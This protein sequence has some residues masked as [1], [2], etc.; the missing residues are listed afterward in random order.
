M[1]DMPP[2]RCYQGTLSYTLSKADYSMGLSMY[3]L[4]SDMNLKNRSRT[5]GYNNEI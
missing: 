5:A 1:H 2:L 3:M 4:P